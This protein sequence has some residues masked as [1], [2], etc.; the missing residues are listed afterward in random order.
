MSTTLEPRVEFNTIA[1]LLHELGDIDPARVRMHPAPGTVTFEMYLGFIKQ[2][3]GR[4]C[5]WVYNTVVEKG[6]GHSQSFVGGV[7]LAELWMHIKAHKLGIMTGEAGPYRILPLI[8]YC[9]DV[10]FVAKDRLPS[11]RPSKE[12]VPE[13]VPNLVVE[14][15]S[16]TNRKGEIKRKL[17]DYFE[18]GVELAWVI[19]PKTRTGREYVAVDDSS[20]IAADGYLE[21][22]TVVP[23]F[24]L[25]LAEVF[26]D[27]DGDF[28]YENEVQA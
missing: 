18:A 26:S 22:G 13:I 1:D 21:G 23:G 5:E 7:I 27:M 6:V 20:F 2:H 28:L 4:T 10:A 9:A 17:R 15:L 8:V 16:D 19:D 12:N 3:T 14:V 11:G 24:R 25:S